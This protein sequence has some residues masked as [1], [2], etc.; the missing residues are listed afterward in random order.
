[1]I[2]PRVDWFG[3]E[4]GVDRCREKQSC[5]LLKVVGGGAVGAAFLCLANAVFTV[6]P[7]NVGEN[8][9]SK[10][11]ILQILEKAKPQLVGKYGLRRIVR[12]PLGSDHAKSLFPRDL[13]A[14]ELRYLALDLLFPCQNGCRKGAPGL[15]A[16]ATPTTRHR[17]LSYRGLFDAKKPF[18]SV[19]IE[20]IFR[21]YIKRSSRCIGPTPT[22]RPRDRRPRYRTPSVGVHVCHSR[23][24]SMV[25]M[26]DS[27]RI[28]P[29]R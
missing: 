15:E 24:I 18:L 7:W 13:I 19:Y 11:E 23:R 3:R 22:A 21:I 28:S 6:Y 2:S 16:H 29:G 25:L 12:W 1:M 5:R 4:L 17:F 14:K 8:M 10:E 20:P 9:K 27:I 26:R